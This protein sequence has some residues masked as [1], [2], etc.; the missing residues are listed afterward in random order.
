MKFTTKTVSSLLPF[1]ILLSS[2]TQPI[3][4]FTNENALKGC[5][6]ILKAKHME[7]EVRGI[8]SLPQTYGQYWQGL[9]AFVVPNENSCSIVRAVFPEFKPQILAF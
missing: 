3:I 1:I 8:D 5:F 9:A 4:S 2:M 6:Y 7:T